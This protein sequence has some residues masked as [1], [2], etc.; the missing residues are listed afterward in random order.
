MLHKHTR[1]TCCIPNC[2]R[3]RWS[4]G[5]CGIHSR[6]LKQ[7]S[8]AEFERLQSLP[9]EEQES[10]FYRTKYPLPP[11][12]QYENPLGEAELIQQYGGNANVK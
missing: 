5:R 4:V 11:K 3:R 6:E 10:E 9:S 12:W 2:E 1:A 7:N 8:P